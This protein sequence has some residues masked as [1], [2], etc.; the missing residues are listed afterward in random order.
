MVKTRGFQKSDKKSKT[1]QASFLNWHD[2][3]DTIKSN[4]KY[5]TKEDKNLVNE[6]LKGWQKESAV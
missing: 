3:G 6:W 4:V 2:M 1:W 5:Q